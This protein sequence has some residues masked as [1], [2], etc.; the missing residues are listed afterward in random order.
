MPTMNA[1]AFRVCENCKDW[2]YIEGTVLDMGDGSFDF[3]EDAE[4]ALKC[5]ACNTLFDGDTESWSLKQPK[6]LRPNFVG[7]G[8]NEDPDA[9]DRQR[10]AR[11]TR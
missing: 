2:Q 1:G 8:E 10:D 7:M 6:R 4:L 3:E 9:Y 11:A 5:E